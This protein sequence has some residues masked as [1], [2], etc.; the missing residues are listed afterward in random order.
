MP[1]EDNG[2]LC[3]TTAKG[4]VAWLQ[5]SWTEWK[6]IFSFEIFGETG[7]L[8]IDG[9]GGSYGVERL[10][11]YR[12]LP[13]M[14]PPETSVWEYPGEDRS[15]E[16]EFADFIRSIEEV[17]RQSVRWR[18]RSLPW[19]SSLRCTRS[20]S[21]DHRTEP[22]TDLLGRWRHRPAVI[23]SKYGGF[24]LAAA[25]D[26]YVYINVHRRSCQTLS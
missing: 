10:T 8:Q 13:E 3:L 16:M 9:L 17:T 20:T 21:H 2:F 14:G 5:V 6:N 23:L 15:W 26:R 1:V 12:M 18:T 25:I 4:G 22:I 11:W 7:K 24:V 19:T